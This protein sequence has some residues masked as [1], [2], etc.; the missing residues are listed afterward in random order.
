MSPPLTPHHTNDYQSQYIHESKVW[1]SS[2]GERPLLLKLRFVVLYCQSGVTTSLTLL[3]LGSRSAYGPGTV[4]W[5]HS[6]STDA[7]TGPLVVKVTHRK[8]LVHP[9][10][11]VPRTVGSREPTPRTTLP[12]G[13]TE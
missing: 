7:D 4:D 11:Y 6:E 13:R 2:V 12:L 10:T 3:A 1:T 5:R 8:Y 9:S